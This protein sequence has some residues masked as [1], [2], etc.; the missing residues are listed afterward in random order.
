MLTT[1]S[2]E[3]VV[4]LLSVEDFV[5]V[6]V[7]VLLDVVLVEVVDSFATVVISSLDVDCGSIS[8]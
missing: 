1:S 8:G 7:E 3:V 4:T 6:V 5:D 2:V